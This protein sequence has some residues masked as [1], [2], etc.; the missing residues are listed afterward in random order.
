MK[1]KIYDNSLNFSGNST[2][3]NRLSKLLNLEKT[4]YKSEK[5]IGIHAYKFGI[6]VINQNV[7]FILVIGGTDLN[8]DIYDQ[9]KRN[10][11]LTALRQAKYIVVFNSYLSKKLILNNIDPS[12]IR[13]ISQSVEKPISSDFNL[14]KKIKMNPKKIYLMI[15][16]LRKEK[17]PLYLED[18]FNCLYDQGI[19]LVVIGKMLEKYEFSKGIIHI[20]GLQSEDV[21]SC[22]KQANGLV[23][24]SI[25]EGMSSS[26]LEAMSL[27]CPVYARDNEGNKS[28]IIDNYNGFLFTDD[29]DFLMCLTKDISFVVEYAYNYVNFFHNPKNESKEYNKLLI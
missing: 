1:Y 3:L 2:T 24:T 4:F 20:D 23:N 10:V 27:R 28:I 13:I 22:M 11:I 7:E 18:T 9:L 17:D 14:R 12:K 26:I 25:C 29:Y 21:Y 5:L 19:V 16:N 8:N 6:N 15:G